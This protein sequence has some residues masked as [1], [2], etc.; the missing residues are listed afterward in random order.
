MR[1]WLPLIM[2]P[3]EQY[4]ELARLAEEIGYEGVALA[5]HVAIPVGF[6]SVHPSGENPFVPESPFPDPFTMVAAMSQVTTRLSFLSFVYILALRDPFT[7]AKQVGT[8]ACLA[9][10]RVRFGVGAG[11]LAEEFGLFGREMR[12]RGRRT[13]E[14]LTVLRDFWDDGYAEHS[15]EFFDVPRSAMFPVPPTPP[16][17]WVGGKSDAA[18]RRAI[19]NDGW[20]GMDYDMEEIERLVPRL[21]DLR[22]EAGD[23]RTDFEVF[24]I[25]HAA[26]SAELFERLAA[27]GVTSTMLSA[28][29]PGD[30]AFASMDA[31]RR[32]LEAAAPLVAASRG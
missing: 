12:G 2:E 21:R 30:P 20:L 9:P 11:W 14:M 32:A 29:P 8:A 25:A 26:P 3:V 16:P 31:K 28:W 1:L 22:A 13:D 4:I 27:L 6:R 23:A 7:A 19:R 18:M 15:G 17:V 5:D 10:G 24:V